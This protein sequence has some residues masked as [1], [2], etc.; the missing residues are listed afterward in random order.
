VQIYEYLHAFLHS[1]TFVVLDGE[2]TEYK[3]VFK[4]NSFH[5][6]PG[7]RN[8]QAQRIQETL[9]GFSFF[10]SYCRNLDLAELS[11]LST[12]DSVKC[13]GISRGY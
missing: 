6:V 8:W 13:F 12:P 3:I 7:W 5:E 4:I 2:G 10:Q 1:F 11:Q 9:V